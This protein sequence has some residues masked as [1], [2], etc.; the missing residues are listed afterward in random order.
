LRLGDV[1]TDTGFDLVTEELRFFDYWLRGIDNGVMREPAVTLLHVQRIDGS[2]WKSSATW[3]PRDT[4]TAFYLGDG[5][6]SPEPPQAR[7]G[8]TRKTVRYDTD[9]ET[10]WSSGMSFLTDPLA[11]DTEVTGHATARLWL[12][13]TARDADIIARI[14]DLA[15]DGTHIYVGVEGKLRASCAPRPR[16]RTRPWACPG[17]R[18]PRLRHSRCSPAFPSKPSSSSC[19]LRTS[20]RPDIASG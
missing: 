11:Q 20:S 18:S 19:R 8:D 16:R 13:S 12:A 9:A 17:T 14:D 1:L 7:D 15:P 10:F 6:L 4:R 2:R 5:A 3:P